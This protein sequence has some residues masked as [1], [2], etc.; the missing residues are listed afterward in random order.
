MVARGEGVAAL[1]QPD[2]VPGHPT[3]GMEI[4][5]WCSP[6]E[7]GWLGDQAAEM[8]SVCEIGSLHGRSAFML[9]TRC[10]GPVYCVDPWDDVKDECYASF[11]RNA[12]Y[13]PNV[14]PVRGYS[15]DALAVVPDVDMAFIDGDHSYEQCKA[16]ILG[17]LPKTR[18]LICG[19]DYQNTNGGFPGVAVAVHEL[20]GVPKVG[21]VVG[22]EMGTSI[23]YVEL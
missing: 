10:P 5:G 12:G 19:H 14:R 18:K 16:D 20:F 9:A 8:D 13:L 2:G 1:M 3:P 7:L 6:V 4:W 23:W 11:M 17:M 21:E 22:A 15:P